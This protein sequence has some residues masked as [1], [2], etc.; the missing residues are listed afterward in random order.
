MYICLSGADRYYNIVTDMIG[1]RPVPYMK[2]CWKFFT[3]CIATVSKIQHLTTQLWMIMQEIRHGRNLASLEEPPATALC[4]CVGH[5]VL[6]ICQIHPSEVQQQLQLPRVGP[7]PRPAHGSL[8][9]PHGASGDAVS[10][11]CD[12]WNNEQGTCFSIWIYMCKSNKF[13]ML[14]SF[15]PPHRDWRH[16]A[17]LQMTWSEHHPRCLKTAVCIKSTNCALW[18]TEQKSI[19]YCNILMDSSNWCFCAFLVN[20]PEKNDQ[21][22]TFNFQGQIVLE[23]WL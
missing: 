23:L 3:P 17:H 18:T 14:S 21:W 6:C 22:L 10:S 4:C 16:W 11:G 7:R 2:Y 9:S 1:N 5:A 12:P 15:D 20:D 13:L 19:H 8:F